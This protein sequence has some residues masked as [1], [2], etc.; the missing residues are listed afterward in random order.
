[1]AKVLWFGDAGCHTGFARVTHSIGDRLV[2]QYGHD[3]HVIAVNFRGD[4]WPTKLKLY[5]PNALEPSDIFGRTRVIE[6]LAKVEPDVVVM[7]GDAN[8]LI[9]LLFEN[10]Y[11]KDRILLQYRPILTYVPVDGYNQPPAWSTVL[12]A[13]TNVVAMSKFGQRMFPGSQLV[14]HGVDT[15]LFYPV[16]DR[17]ITL[18]TGHVVSTKAECKAAFG[19][20]ED[21][22]LVLRVDKNSGRK[23][24]PATWK[25][26]VPVMQRHENVI[27]HFHTQG[28]AGDNGIML[29]AMFSR[30]P[31]LAERFKLPEFM[32]GFVGWPEEDLCALYNAAD[33]FVTTSRGEGFGLTIAEAMAT[34]L[35]VVAQ[36]VS[37]IPEVVGP[38]GVLVEPQRLLTVPSG[39]DLWLADVEAFTETI[40]RLYADPDERARLGALAREHVTNFSWDKAAEQFN[41]FITS[42]AVFEPEAE[43]AVQLEPRT[44][45]VGAG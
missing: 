2:E 42:M 34:G 11:D 22:F 28:G 33:L 27:A 23:D 39:Q 30:E 18:S 37:A 17:P 44:T 40:E 32:T 24:W 15:D 7:L 19:Y 41:H 1:M 31:A 14:Y 3:I 9:Q 12:S 43:D 8:I 6:M 21:D 45:A 36:R 16:A 10:S 5:R 26:L 4:Y 13:V 38:G 29:N 25:A 35:P 20:K